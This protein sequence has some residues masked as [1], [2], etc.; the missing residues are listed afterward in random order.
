MSD[1]D[2]EST[3]KAGPLAGMPPLT[4]KALKILDHGW[5]AGWSIRPSPTRRAWKDQ[6]PHAYKR[7]P[8][9]AANL[10]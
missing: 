8:L 1:L 7:L 3:P 6:H 10:W 5:G 4:F 2:N 9:V